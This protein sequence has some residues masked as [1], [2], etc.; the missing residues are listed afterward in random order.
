MDTKNIT[1]EDVYN[2]YSNIRNLGYIWNDPK[3]ENVG[4][5]INV[6]G[7][8]IGDK[9]YLPQYQYKKGDLV[10]I[11]LEDIAYVGEETDDIVL[12]EITYSSYNRN[13]YR[14]ETRNMEEKKQRKH[15]IKK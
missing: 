3:E 13:V 7:C 8:K 10:V 11:D 1:L 9:K 12:T 2:A 6:E 14:F 5:I 4:R 15:G